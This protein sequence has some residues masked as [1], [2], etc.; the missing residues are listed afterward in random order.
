MMANNNNNIVVFKRGLNL[1]IEQKVK[2][3]LTAILADVAQ[4]VVDYIDQISSRTNAEGL[5]ILTGAL[6]D[7]SGVGVYRDGVLSA[8][9]PRQIYNTREGSGQMFSPEDMLDYALSWGAQRLPTGIWL[10][11]FSSMPYAAQIDTEGSPIGRGQGFFYE[12]I[13]PFAIDAL[14]RR[15]KP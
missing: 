14:R 3:Q 1:F 6:H 2:P 13:V 11:I 5:P 15:M 9:R 8:Y 12:M 7:A 10:V 4:D